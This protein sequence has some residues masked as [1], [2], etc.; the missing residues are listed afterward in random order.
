MNART[1]AEGLERRV[2]S[3]EH[4]NRLLVIS[5][6]ILGGAA[7]LAVL[8]GA[9]ES[10]PPELRVSDLQLVDSAGKTRLR[11]ALEPD[12]QPS[13][14]FLNAAGNAQLTLALPNSG[15]PEI[16][17]SHANGTEQLALRLT[18]G[19]LPWITFNNSKG[20]TVADLGLNSYD[21][22]S[23]EMSSGDEQRHLDLRFD[24]SGDFG[25]YAYSPDYDTRVSLGMDPDGKPTLALRDPSERPLATLAVD[26][27][28]GHAQ[29]TLQD[30][31]GKTL[32]I[33]PS[34]K[35]P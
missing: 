7:V 20:V 34:R 15:E 26:D 23:L 16:Q 6:A 13:L 8:V 3:L 2:A 5:M 11:L 4:R 31:K 33:A 24:E 17:L 29:F 14:K 1:E 30:A 12:G 25:F 28:V 18:N 10:K 9:A 22:P 19:N 32:F 35:K 27:K 21:A